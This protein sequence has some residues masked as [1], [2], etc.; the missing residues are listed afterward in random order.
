MII[1]PLIKIHLLMKKLH[2]NRKLPKKIHIQIT[3]EER[4]IEK[5]NHSS[6]AQM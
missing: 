6:K 1:K 4:E 2:N 5:E 3:Q